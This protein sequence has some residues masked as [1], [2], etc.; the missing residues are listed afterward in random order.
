VAVRIPKEIA[1]VLSIG[2]GTSVDFTIRGDK[3]IISKV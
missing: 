2:A 1:D 3:M